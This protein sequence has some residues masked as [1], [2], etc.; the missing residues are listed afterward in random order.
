MSDGFRRSRTLPDLSTPT[1]VNYLTKSLSAQKLALS[2]SGEVKGMNSHA[3]R[4]YTFVIQIVLYGCLGL[5]LFGAL[6]VYASGKSHSSDYVHHREDTWSYQVVVKEDH[7]EKT[8][9]SES[10][11]R[12]KMGMQQS[13][14]FA[15]PHLLV[16]VMKALTFEYDREMPLYNDASP[17][18]KSQ[19]RK[20]AKSRK[21]F[22]VAGKTLAESCPSSSSIRLFVGIASRASIKARLKRNAIRSSWLEDMRISFSDAV[23][24]T[25]LVSQPS[26]DS[27]TELKDIAIDLV[28]EFEEY[29]DIAIVPG[30]ENYMALPTKTFSMM[31]YALASSCQYTHIL[32]TDDD[33]YLRLSYLLQ[34]IQA[35]IYHGELNIEAKST[36]D[37]YQI[38]D[39]KEHSVPVKPWNS[40]L[41]IGKIDRNVSGIFP[42]FSPVRDPENK[43]YLS[44]EN[45]P[46]DLGPS[47]IRW[48]SGWGYL[49]SRDVTA[50]ALNGAYAIASSNADN[51]PAWWGRLPWED[52]V[53]ATL[54][55]NYTKLYHH[56][57]FKAAW[58]SCR[59]DTV[60]KHLDNQAPSLVSGLRE[61]DRSGLWKV[62]EV[63]CS[64]GLYRPGYYN[65]WRNWRNS[66]PDTLSVGKM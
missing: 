53:V 42:G 32:K 18:K 11:A 16:P 4:D 59:N 30:P 26:P 8:L 25:F 45:Y 64:S 51:R 20:Y 60:L 57:G 15:K 3:F 1:R 9:G 49:M 43:W 22:E 47:N 19:R 6:M 7:Y 2:R 48:V 37:V 33:V 31:R 14:P 52:V 34:I 61:Q 44:E 10:S 39:R 12:L 28:D 35:G 21:A 54:L 17:P 23:R 46:D 56:E 38:I 24:G 55:S 63:V 13:I 29:N 50:K 41:Y 65:E 66:L 36:A 40:H 27:Q 5:M 58:D 62:K